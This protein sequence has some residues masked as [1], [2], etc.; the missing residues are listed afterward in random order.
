MKILFIGSV[1]FSAAALIK[2][3]D[4][5]ASIVGV[6]TSKKSTFNSDH[7]NLT[8]IADLAEIPVFETADI[9][10]L[11]ALNWIRSRNPDIIFCFGW[12]QIIRAPLLA[13]PPRGVIGF[14]P[15]AL[16]ANRGR[17]PLIWA[18]VLG[19]QETASTFF[20]MDQGADSGDI[21]SQEIVPIFTSDDARSLYNKIT[22]IAMGQIADF[23]PSLIEGDFTL[24]PQNHSIANK[25]RL[26]SELDGEIDWRMTAKSICNLIRGL[27]KPYPGA[28]FKYGENKI[29]VWS[30]EVI[31][32]ENINIEPG[33]ILA[34]DQRGFL[35]KAGEHSVRLIKTE[36]QLRLNVGDYL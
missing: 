24:K 25:W 5:G 17:H 19:L 30:A 7:V 9:N 2:L 12:S 29:K 20:L 27:A 23:L 36:P 33:K 4:M 34:I 35:V 10:N 11:D 13:I 6:C 3:I 1:E 22:T 28:H 31:R 21:L 15:A 16:P 18:L 8:S 32:D 26:R 14:H